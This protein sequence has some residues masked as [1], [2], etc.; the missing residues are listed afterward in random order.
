M[1]NT[2][3]YV[4]V[5]VCFL[6]VLLSPVDVVVAGRG[7][8]LPIPP[9]RRSGGGGNDQDFVTMGTTVD[10]K[11]EVFQEREVKGCKPKGTSH[12]SAPSRYVNFH[13]L[14]S[15]RCSTAPTRKP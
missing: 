14:G 11:K 2:S 8:P 1:S 13:T 4:N 7:T 6:L 15:L 9:A 3:L 5:L 10:H 12:S